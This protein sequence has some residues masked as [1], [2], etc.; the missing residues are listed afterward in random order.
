MRGSGDLGFPAGTALLL[1]TNDLAV[2]AKEETADSP[3]KTTPASGEGLVGAC[4]AP[5]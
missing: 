1:D 2:L 4:D 3:L 5:S